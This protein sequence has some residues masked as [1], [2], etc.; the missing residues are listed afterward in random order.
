MDKCVDSIREHM[1]VGDFSAWQR[2]RVIIDDPER[3]VPARRALLEVAAAKADQRIALGVLGLAREWVAALPHAKGDEIVSGDNELGRKLVLLHR[4]L[5]LLEEG[6]LAD[7][8]GARPETLDLLR[9]VVTETFIDPQKGVRATRLIASSGAPLELRRAT[10]EAI[11]AAHGRGTQ[12]PLALIRLLDSSSLPK[13]RALV[14]QSNDPDSFHFGAAAALAHLGDREILPDLEA[15]RPS[16]RKKHVNIEN[17][18]VYYIWQINVQHPAAK[19]LEYIASAEDIGRARPRMW[20]VRRALELGL[21]REKIRAAVL[22]HASKVEPK[23]FRQQTGRVVEV[24]PS[25]S[26]IK[27]EAIEL[28]VLRADDLPEVKIP[29]AKPTP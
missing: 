13:L 11:I 21:D 7:H 19:L 2:L 22:E 26:T 28:G 25:L 14:R 23:E 27:A 1:A 3:P 24:W 9:E 17:Y 12:P 8:L 20:A 4:F 29:A 15:A 18:V 6:P 5:D 16:L 10:A